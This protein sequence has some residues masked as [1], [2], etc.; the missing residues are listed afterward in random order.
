M[1][2]DRVDAAA[3]AGE[4]PAHSSCAAAAAD[5]CSGS[6]FFA[7]ARRPILKMGAAADAPFPSPFPTSARGGVTVA[8]SGSLLVSGPS[9]AKDLWVPASAAGPGT[10]SEG[11]PSR[12]IPPRLN[13]IRGQRLIQ[14]TGGNP[15]TALPG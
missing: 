13:Y 2:V 9:A 10:A 12:S 3:D 14:M 5:R 15:V 4:G 8:G 6:F 11:D 1:A 7:K